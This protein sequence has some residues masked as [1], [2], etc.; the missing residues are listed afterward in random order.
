[1]MFMWIFRMIGLC[2]YASIYRQNSLWFV[3]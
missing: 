1:M 3:W 2:N